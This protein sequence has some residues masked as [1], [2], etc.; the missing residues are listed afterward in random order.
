MHWTERGTNNASISE[1][2]RP[3]SLRN[4]G[5]GRTTFSQATAPP[6]TDARVHPSVR[7]VHPACFLMVFEKRNVPNTKNP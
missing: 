1:P 4:D 2:I 7:V 5:S 3:D 6:G